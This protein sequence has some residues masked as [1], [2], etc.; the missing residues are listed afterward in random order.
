MGKVI[1]GPWG[2]SNAVTKAEAQGTG[3][4]PVVPLRSP[5]PKRTGTARPFKF[6]NEMLA[7]VHIAI[8]D[9]MI[10]TRCSWLTYWMECPQCG[11]AIRP[12]TDKDYRTFLKRISGKTSCGDMTKFEL[13]GVI[14]AL[15][16]AGFMDTKHM[17]L[18]RAASHKKGGMARAAEEKAKLVLGRHWKKR[19]NGWISKVFQVDDISFLNTRQLRAVF[20]FLHK[21]QKETEPF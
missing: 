1:Q 4:A 3:S 17:Q 8:K 13:E 19:L 16:S 9:L 10:C 7:K 21:V 5:K 12:I 6:R 18:S 15:R 20:G 14:Y 2:I 11:S